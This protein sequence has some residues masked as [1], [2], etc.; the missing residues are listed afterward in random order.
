MS[1]YESNIGF[2]I[3]IYKWPGSLSALWK[4]RRKWSSGRRQGWSSCAVLSCSTPTLSDTFG[5]RRPIILDV[6]WGRIQKQTISDQPWLTG[7]GVCVCRGIAS[8]LDH[9][10][11]CDAK[12]WFNVHVSVWLHG[13]QSDPWSG[14]GVGGEWARAGIGTTVND[15]S[16]NSALHESLLEQE[17]WCFFI[18]QSRTLYRFR[19]CL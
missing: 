14:S 3:Y 11:A 4:T 13:I 12:H 7:L 8:L 18:Y 9:I 1:W 15:Y 10:L 19:P 6:I 16:R 5:C 17:N 2:M